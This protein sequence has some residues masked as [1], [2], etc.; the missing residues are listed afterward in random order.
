ML[1]EADDLRVGGR[2]AL[3]GMMSMPDN[4]SSW[5][6][7]MSIFLTTVSYYITVPTANAYAEDLGLD[8]SYT[9]VII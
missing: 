8:A 5:L 1:F 7:I 9:G 3:A 6:N 4:M 2:E